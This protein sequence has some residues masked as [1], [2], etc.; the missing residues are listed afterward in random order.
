MPGGSSGTVVA[1][2]NGLGNHNDQLD[3]AASVVVDKNGTVFVCDFDNE[4]VQRWFKTDNHGQTIIA[5][6]VCLG[7]AIDSEESVYVTGVNSVTKWP[8]NQIVAGGNGEGNA[9][10]QL[11]EPY[12]LFVDGDQT[13]FVADR[14]VHRV[15]KWP[16]GAKEGIVVAGGNGEGFGVHQLN[17]PVSVVVDQMGTVYVAD[18]FNHRI[19]RW[20]KDA[21]SGSIIVG[22]RGEGSGRDQFSYPLDLEFDQQGN[23]YV[24]DT[25]NHRIQMFAIDKSSC[26][27]SKF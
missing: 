18:T 19:M 9:L 8:S 27:T 1:G 20:F 3:Q 13:V 23:L 24:A 17:K 4:R 14:Y 7:L 6:S 11:S 26:S 10:N 5:N 15:M 21:K 16:V 2:G 12:H 25:F 22:Q